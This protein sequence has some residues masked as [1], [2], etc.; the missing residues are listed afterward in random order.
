MDIHYKENMGVKTPQGRNLDY[1]QVAKMGL[2]FQTNIAYAEISIF[3]HLIDAEEGKPP[4]ASRNVEW[5]V[6]GDTDIAS[7]FSKLLS[8]DS[9][10]TTSLDTL[11]FSGSELVNSTPELRSKPVTEANIEIETEPLVVLDETIVEDESFYNRFLSF[12]KRMFSF[13]KR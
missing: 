10:S 7:G 3:E 4:A 1:F 2:N 11:S 5:A 12:F 8:F 9:V 13:L 6:G